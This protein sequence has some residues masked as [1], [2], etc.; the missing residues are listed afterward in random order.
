MGLLAVLAL[1][2]PRGAATAVPAQPRPNVVVLMTDDQSI[3]TLGAMPNVRALLARQG[4]TFDRSFVSF[5]LCCPSRATFL[6]G[7]YAHNHHVRGNRLPFGGYE[8]LDKHEW[9]PVWLQRA[10]YRTIQ[11][12]KFLNGYGMGNPYEVPPGWDEWY[13]SV[14][15]STY[16]YY[17]YTFNENGVLHTYGAD[18]D[19]AF[20]RTD[21]EGRRAEQIID[22]VAPS[23]QPFFFTFQFLAPHTAAPVEDDDPFD[24]ATPARAPRHRGRF[25]DAPLPKPPSYNER[26][27]SDKPRFIRRRRLISPAREASVRALYQQ[28]LES[29]EAVD[30]AVA[31]VVAALTRAGELENTLILFTSDNGFLLGEHRVPAG[32]ILPYEPSIR[33]PLIM[34]GPGV[35]RGAHRRQLV[36]NADLAPTILDAAGATPGRRQDGRS[37]FPLLRDSR[38]EWGRSLLI[39]GGFGG[40]HPFEAVRTYRYLYVRYRNRAREL[41]DLRRDPY[42]LRSLHKSRRYAKIRIQLDRRVRRLRRCK[43]RGCRAKPRVRM[44]LLPDV[45]GCVATVGG[46]G[47]VAVLFRSGRGA[48]RDRRRPFARLVSGRRV[49]A[50]VSLR[51][52]D[53]VTLDRRLRG[54]CR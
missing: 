20:Y 35:P 52:G 53:V 49:R 9:L 28:R 36:T 2:I 24:Q 50:R 7:Q 34:R 12:G 47:V 5:S 48:S 39:E 31:K 41:Y 11:L 29:L 21:F 15:P 22:R 16:R 30:D 27:M 51:A 3:H 23:N 54:R 6:T 14:D 38:L 42:E 45:E 25:K 32:K 37:L 17:D 13:T 33:V 26:D 46:R 19:P 8:K 44:R 10:G 18:G 40:L 4:T 43:G 1:A